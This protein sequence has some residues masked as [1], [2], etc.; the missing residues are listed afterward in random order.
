[1]EKTIKYAE[2][3]EIKKGIAFSDPWYDETVWC[4]YRK[5][6][7]DKD[8]VMKL[9]T[10]R[11]EDNY[12]NM[13]MSIGRRTL[14]AGLEC[15]ETNPELGEFN[16]SYPSRFQYGEVELGIDTAKIFV[17]SLD[18]FEKFAEEAAVY[19]AADGMFGN[20]CV[21]TCKG[22]ENPAGFLLFAAVD[23]EIAE[24]EALYQTLRSS[25]D[26]QEIDKAKFE[27]LT[28]LSDLSLRVQAASELRHAKAAEEKQPKQ[29]EMPT[30][31]VD[32]QH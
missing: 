26:G 10:R 13:T 30:R 20:L 23:G 1:M 14:M 16:L 2:I 17:G 18:N 28:A 31:S 15:E 4:Q 29:Q 6:F 19:T 8:W 9:E 22:E 12:I 25:F 7:S 27:S 11:D 24:E 5:E 32:L 21:F 3:P